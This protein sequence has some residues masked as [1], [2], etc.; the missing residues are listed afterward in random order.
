MENKALEIIEVCLDFERGLVVLKLFSAPEIGT[1]VG[2]ILMER[3]LSWEIYKGN[4]VH[5]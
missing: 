5:T 4:T 1:K 3:R 2:C